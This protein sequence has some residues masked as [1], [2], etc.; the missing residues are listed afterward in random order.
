[1]P[2]LLLG[3]APNNPASASANKTKTDAAGVS[4]SLLQHVDA[5]L[6]E[7]PMLVIGNVQLPFAVKLRA[8]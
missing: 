7:L 6:D 3:L 5:C 2:A 1:M 4:C 8:A